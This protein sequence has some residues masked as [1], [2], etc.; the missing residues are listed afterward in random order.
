[1]IAGYAVI[2]IGLHIIITANAQLTFYRRMT[3]FWYWMLVSLVIEVLIIVAF[4]LIVKPRKAKPET[5]KDFEDRIAKIFREQGY[6][7][8]RID[9]F[10]VNMILKKAGMRAAVRILFDKTNT[11]IDNAPVNKIAADK[12][13]FDCDQAMIVTNYKYTPRAHLVAK[14]LH[15]TLWDRSN[16]SR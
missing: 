16:I 10:R 1:M 8:E 11:L 14:K 5:G 13:E 9:D 2:F 3:P 7:V 12:K 6:D 4:K 15:V